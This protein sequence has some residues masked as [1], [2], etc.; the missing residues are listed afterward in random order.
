MK[1]FLVLVAG[2]SGKRM[3]T[4][5]PKQFL[6]INGRPIFYYTIARFLAAGEQLEIILVIH[7]A[8][9]TELNEFLQRYFPDKKFQL[10]DGGATRF[11]SVK[12]GLALIHDER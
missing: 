12:N 5:I 7:P 10:A 2:G 9:K 3:G 11:H 8:W 4:S 1:T 6:E